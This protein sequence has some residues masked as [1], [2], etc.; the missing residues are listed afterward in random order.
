MRRTVVAVALV[1]AA[2]I[3]AVSVTAAQAVAKPAASKPAKPEASKPAKPA[4]PAKVTFAANGS[5]TA[6]SAD[7]ATITV[8]VKSGTKDVKGRTVI[9]SVPSTTRIV[10]NGAGRALSALAAG[11]RIT[12]T[13]THVGSAYTAAKIEAHGVRTQP[14]P[15]ASPTAAP[16]PTVTESPS[17]EPTSDPSAEPTSDPSTEP[18]SG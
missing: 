12:V 7:A 2:T 1:A 11:Y 8:A 3:P 14:T 5:V 17:A 15:T 13:G 6:V 10:V 4:K 18:V 16:S 9:I